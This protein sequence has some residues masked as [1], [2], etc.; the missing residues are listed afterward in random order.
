VGGA[1][2]RKGDRDR[3]LPAAA[4]GGTR[5]T[6]RGGRGDEHGAIEALDVV[7]E[8]LDGVARED[9]SPAG[10]A[11]P[12]AE[13]G[14]AGELLEPVGERDHVSGLDQEAVDAVPHDVRY[15]ADAARNDRSPRRQRLDRDDGGAL[16]RGGKDEDVE[17]GVPGGDLPLVA[18]V[19]AVAGD[20]EPAGLPLDL[21]PIGSV[22]DHQE[23]HVDTARPQQLHGGQDVA[24]PL[25]A[26]HASD[27]ADD[28]ALGRDPEQPAAASAR[29]RIGSDPILELDAEPD[30]AEARSR[31]DAEGDQVVPHLG[32]DCDQDV[33]AG[34]EQ[35]FQHPERRTADRSEVAV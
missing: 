17:G 35:T 1:A 24:R 31:R 33:R 25:H 4:R 10:G 26:R 29:T 22:A 8:P 20:S 16:V 15:A 23:R 13:P 32:A 27:P 18:E 30:H 28:E 11:H 9:A 5:G 12:L 3:A 21:V 14:V 2:G 6:A 19:E 34:R 7:D